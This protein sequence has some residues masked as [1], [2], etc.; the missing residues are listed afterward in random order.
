VEH[1]VLAFIP[2]V[3]IVGGLGLAVLGVRHR[4]KIREL[5]HRERLAMIERGLTPPPEVDPE[6]FEQLLASSAGSPRAGKHRS[7]GVL[8]IG[9]GFGLMLIIGFAS[10]EPGVAFGI[11]GGLMALGGAFLANSMLA[12]RDQ[13]MSPPPASSSERNSALPPVPPAS[14]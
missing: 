8:L 6:R 14:S 2:I 9:V 11:G 5:Q 13:R 12:A 1:V 7:A 4:Y 10:G 3:A